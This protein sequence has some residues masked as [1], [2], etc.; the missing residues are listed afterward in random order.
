M[1]LRVGLWRRLSTEE[2]IL[3]NFGVGEESWESLGLQGDQSV[4]P[5]GNKPW[6]FIGRT[7]AE[8][9]TPIFGQLMGRTDSLE[10]TLILGNIEGRRRGWQRMRCLDVITDLMYMSLSKLQELVMDWESWR[11]AVHRAAKNRPRLSDG[12]EPIWF[13]LLCGR[14]K[15]NVVKQLFFN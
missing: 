7:D 11:A 3:F 4:H 13:M 10:K 12:T 5:K 1:D 6:I 8:A 2:L 9:E 14:N 15:H